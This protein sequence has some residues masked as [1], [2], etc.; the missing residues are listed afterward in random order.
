MDLVF[1]NRALKWLRFGMFPVER[2]PLPIHISD[3][4]LSVAIQEASYCTFYLSITLLKV[5]RKSAINSHPSKVST[6]VIY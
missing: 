2:L 5:T 1:L 4:C 6:T 3:A